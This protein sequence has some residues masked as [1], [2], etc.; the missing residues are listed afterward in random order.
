M[1]GKF[2]LDILK[3]KLLS[4]TQLDSHSHQSVHSHIMSITANLRGKK[5]KKKARLLLFTFASC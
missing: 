3:K 4:N 2:V 5:K 1:K